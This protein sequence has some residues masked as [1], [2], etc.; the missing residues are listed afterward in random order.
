MQ[1]SVSMDICIRK[2]SGE[3]G[4]LFFSIQDLFS[5]QEGRSRLNFY[6]LVTISDENITVR[7]YSLDHEEYTLTCKG[8]SAMISPKI[9]QFLL[10][11]KKP[12]SLLQTNWLLSLTAIIWTMPSSSWATC[13]IPES[14]WWPRTI[15]LLGL[16]D[17][18]N[19]PIPGRKWAEWRRIISGYLSHRQK[20]W[21]TVKGELRTGW[22]LAFYWWVLPASF[23]KM[24]SFR[25]YH[26]KIHSKSL[27]CLG[28][29]FWHHWEN[30]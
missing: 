25:H 2:E 6:A 5:A 28:A 16:S 10:S 29:W 12:S 15:A 4:K 1:T 24:V 18:W 26:P 19:Y 3:K 20:M 9:E 13:L 14:L 8:F 30:K 27:Q 11:R 22:G 21:A 23:G 7:F 17:Q